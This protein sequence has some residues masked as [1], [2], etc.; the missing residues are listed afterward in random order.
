MLQGFQLALSGSNTLVLLLGTLIGLVVGILPVVGPS[1]GV[2]LALPFTFGLD[3]AA[4][5]ILLTA[6]QSASAYG[7]SIASVLLNVPGGPGTVATCWEGYPLSRKGRAGTALGVC[8]LA[9]FVGGI[10]GWLSLAFLAAMFFADRVLCRDTALLAAVASAV[11]A[12]QSGL[13]FLVRRDL[14]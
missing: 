1:F 14:Y 9:S 12:W 2:T 4:A 7:D 13:R 10:M 6:I 3:P 8:T 11:F 5:L